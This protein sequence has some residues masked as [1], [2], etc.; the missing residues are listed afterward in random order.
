MSLISRCSICGKPAHASETDDLDRCEECTSIIVSARARA[1]SGEGIKTH[2]F[3]V[4][5]DTV[6][7][8]DS[9]AGHYTCVHALSRSAC[10]RIRKLARASLTEAARLHVA[11]VLSMGVLTAADIAAQ[12]DDVATEGWSTDGLGLDLNSIEDRHT[13]AKAIREAARE[14]ERVLGGA[15]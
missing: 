6:R 5:S 8:W 12:P 1:F 3:L 4:S 13:L 9:V 2:K 11:D 10:A 15:A 14:V 7:V